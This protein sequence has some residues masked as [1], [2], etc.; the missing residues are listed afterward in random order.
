MGLLTKKVL[1]TVKTYP[2]L[3]S[4]YGELVCTAGITEDG[5][6]IRI[7]PIPFRRLK[8]YYRFEKYTWIE[9]PLEKNKQDPRPESFRPRDLS[10]IKILEHGRG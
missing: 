2:T 9:L 8:E 10:E 3:S 6:W 5:S 1:V 7:Y 4:T